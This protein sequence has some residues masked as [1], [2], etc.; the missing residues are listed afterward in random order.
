[1]ARRAPYSLIYDPEVRRHLRA[2]EAG[3]HSLI[4]MTIEEQLRFEPETAT[5]NRKPLRWP[6]AFE[7]T[8]ELR[9]GPGNRFRV[10]YVVDHDRHEVQIL[11]IGV[12]DRNRLTIGGEEVEL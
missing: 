9:F 1:M 3:Y 5:R 8:W 4:R 7:A 2:I 12:K 6:V 10:F 11:A